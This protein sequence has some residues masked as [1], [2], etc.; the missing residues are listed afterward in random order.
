M[1][2]FLEGNKYIALYFSVKERN[3]LDDT[4]LNNTVMRWIDDVINVLNGGS[5]TLVFLFQI[6]EWQAMLYLINT[7]KDRDINEILYDHN[8][9]EIHDRTGTLKF[10]R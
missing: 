10:R 7:Q 8:A 6:F 9:E 1:A 5:L 2:R 4:V 3:C